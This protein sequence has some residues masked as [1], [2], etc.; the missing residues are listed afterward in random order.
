MKMKCDRQVGVSMRGAVNSRWNRLG[1]PQEMYEREMELYHTE[2]VLL[3]EGFYTEPGLGGKL[4][5]D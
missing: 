3:A 5:A 2:E 1:F 4:V